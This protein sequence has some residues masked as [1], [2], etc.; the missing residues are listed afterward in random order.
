V[1]YREISPSSSLS[2]GREAT[3]P[4]TRGE[5]DGSRNGANVMGLKQAGK[6]N[7]TEITSGY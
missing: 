1:N 5:E 7:N 2:D 3:H 6:L 4:S